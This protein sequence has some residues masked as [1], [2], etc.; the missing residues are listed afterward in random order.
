M[1]TPA[2]AIAEAEYAV[3]ELGAKSVL[4]AGYV[5]RPVGRATAYR[6]DMFGIDSEHD[7]DPFWATCV[8]LGVAPVVHSSLQ[9]HRVTRSISNYVYN[10]VERARRRA[11][12][13]VQVAVPRR[14]DAPVPRAC[15]SGSSRAAWRG[16][17]RCSRVWSVTGR[18]ATATRS[19]RSTPTGSTSTRSSATSREYGDDDVRARLDDI[20]DVLR[21]SGGAARAASTSSRR[22]E[23][24]ARR[25]PPRSCSSPAST[26]GAKPTT[27]WWRGRSA[28]T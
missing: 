28:T 23:I 20:R 5:K 7:Y 27:R 14:G 13:A 22:C 6:L 3:R 10:H 11:R 16:R 21:S 24:D 18:S 15:A 26:S 9:S 19:A 1:N 8:E 12:V 4:I 25:R 17:A 2:Q